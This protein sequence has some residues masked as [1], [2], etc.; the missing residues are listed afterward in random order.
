MTNEEKTRTI[1]ALS[2]LAVARDKQLSEVQ[3]EMWLEDLA[4]FAVE[5]IERAA[6]EARRTLKFFPTQV[7]FIE[8]IQGNGDDRAGQAWAAF[9][10]AATDGGWASVKFLDPATAAAVDNVFG[11]WLAACRALHNAEEPM[12]AHYR[13]AFSSAYQTAR[14]FPQARETYY[15]GQY[16]IENRSGGAWA[17]KMQTIISPVLVIG[18]REAKEVRLPFDAATGRLTA[19]AQALIDGAATAEGAQKLLEFAHRTNP[20]ALNAAPESTVDDAPVGREEAARIVA[21]IESKTGLSLVKPM[22][23]A[24]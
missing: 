16:E 1:T 18:L 10:A 22:K 5:N 12:I 8:L 6:I 24:A 11:G 15:A 20:P 19:E 2:R 13:K 21:E 9:L 3:L 4:S 17:A 7:E 23:G 14:K